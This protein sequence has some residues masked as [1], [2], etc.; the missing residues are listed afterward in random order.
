MS[1]SEQKHLR[2]LEAAVEVFTAAGFTGA[3]MD[4]I[5]SHADVSKRTLYTHFAGKAALFETI[6]KRARDEFAN[7][8]AAKYD[9]RRPIAQQLASI[10]AAEGK[11]FTDKRFMR[12]ASL[13]WIESARH[14]DLA[15][16]L[17][18]M[19][20]GEAGLA[21]FMKAAMAAGALRKDDPARA[22]THFKDLLKARAFWPQLA[23]GD[24]VTR[25]KMAAIE[26]EAVSFFLSHYE[27]RR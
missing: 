4:A 15:A 14:G 12:T 5:A 11:L 22:A 23:R 18:K 27:A 8:Y 26:A 13:L 3:T 21:G 1:L 6:A 19:P 20:E 7:A 2:I 10:A 9:P 16:R 17:P 24:A 25:A